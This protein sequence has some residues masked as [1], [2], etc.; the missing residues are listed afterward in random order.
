MLGLGR[1][2]DQ[3]FLLSGADELGIVSV[4]VSHNVTGYMGSVHQGA[5]ED[6]E[7]R[8]HKAPA[9]LSACVP[10][11]HWKRWLAG[12]KHRLGRATC[13][14]GVPWYQVRMLSGWKTRGRAQAL[15][16]GDEKSMK[17]SSTATATEAAFL[18]VWPGL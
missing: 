9:W 11:V 8:G 10:Y 18:L 3:L 7:G 15:V 12:L 4:E 14:P 17:P 6:P 1:T 2:R 5:V 13:L 16:S